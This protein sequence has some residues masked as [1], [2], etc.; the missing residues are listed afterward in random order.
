MRTC[1]SCN[2]EKADSHFRK[3]GRG[4]KKSCKACEARAEGEAVI[5]AAADDTPTPIRLDGMRLEIARGY[6]LRASAESDQLVIEQDTD[7]EGVATVVLSK[8][9]FKVLAAQFSEWAA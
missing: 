7:G 4:L 5:S 3:F 1:E 6:G 8:T 9:E 2:V